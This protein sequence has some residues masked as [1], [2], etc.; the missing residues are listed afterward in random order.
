MRR[1]LTLAPMWAAAAPPWASCPFHAYPHQMILAFLERTQQM[2][3]RHPIASSTRACTWAYR[4][5]H[6]AARAHSIISDPNSDHPPTPHESRSVSHRTPPTDETN[7]PALATLAQSTSQHVCSLYV[8]TSR[9]GHSTPTNQPHLF[10]SP[11]LLL[12]F[13][14][15][16]TLLFLVSSAQKQQHALFPLP[17]AFHVSSQSNPKALS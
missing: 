16:H 7:E 17:C 8:P 13:S 12:A 3:K 2:L 15:S 5:S 14:R 1:L 9:L 4:L 6:P 10:P 11:C